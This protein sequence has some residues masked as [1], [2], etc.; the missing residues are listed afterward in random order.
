MIYVNPNLEIT[1]SLIK[2]QTLAHLIWSRVKTFLSSSTST[3]NQSQFTITSF[4]LGEK[5]TT[6]R[7]CF[8]LNSYHCRLYCFYCL[9]YTHRSTSTSNNISFPYHSCSHIS[10]KYSGFVLFSL[11]SFLSFVICSLFISS[12]LVAL[13]NLCQTG[14]V[15]AYTQDFQQ[16]ARTVGWAKTLLMSLYQHSLK[17]NIQL[18]MVMSNV[19]QLKESNKDA[20]PHPQP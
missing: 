13:K 20:P 18:T 19:R 11:I 4:Q 17:E 2:N 8:C 15:L 3:L 1:H 16:P 14:T 10:Y 12:V 5:C 6:P 7:L 9:T